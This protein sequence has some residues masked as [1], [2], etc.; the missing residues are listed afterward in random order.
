MAK[1][2]WLGHSA[3]LLE[4][5]DRVLLDPFLTGN[6][7]AKTRASDVRANVVLVTHGHGDHVGDTVDI[8]KNN[9]ATVASIYELAVRFEAKGAKT[10]PL[11]IGG[12][13]RISD[14]HVK[15][16]N[17]LHSSDVFE[18]EN[19]QAGG[20]PAGFVISSGVTVYHAGD[21][22]YFGDMKWIGE[23]HKPKIAILPIGDRYTMGVKEAAYAASVIAPEIVIPMHYNTFKLIE[24]NSEEFTSEVKKQS[25]G[26]VKARI[27]K[28][29]ETIEI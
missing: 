24:Q 10:E 11:N 25:N 29:G 19:L 22:G 20:N 21:T 3:F 23:F 7:V 2:T 1:L 4:G 5:K 28:V 26:K 16:V 15:M 18:G 12:G 9:K 27:M 13:V 14:T 17:A 8:A 6:P